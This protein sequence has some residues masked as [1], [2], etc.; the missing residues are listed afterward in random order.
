M[1]MA[2]ENGKMVLASSKMKRNHFTCPACN[3]TVFLRAGS[4]KIAHFAHAKDSDCVASEGETREHLLGKKQLFNW[5]KRHQYKPVYEVYLPEIKQRP[6]LLIKIG[7]QTVALEYQCSPISL[8]RL[9]ERN[10]GY[11]KMNIKVWWIL[12]SPYRHRRL[13]NVKVAQFTQFIFNRFDLLFWNTTEERF[14]YGQQYLKIDFYKKRYSKPWSKQVLMQQT[15][16]IN[17]QVMEGQPHLQEIVQQCYQAGHL[18]VGIPLVGHYLAEQWPSTCNGL[19][20]WQTQVLLESEKFQLGQQW[21]LTDWY[22]WLDQVGQR[23]WFLFPCLGSLNQIKKK[24]LQQFTLALQRYNV[25]A[26]DQ[27]VSYINLPQWFKDGT[28]KINYIRAL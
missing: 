6:D 25:I 27:D 2:V 24:Y 14:S 8:T 1:L 9:Q 28:A 21:S 19:T 18:F 5:A 26:I 7:R 11:R 16:S 3:Q 13:S 12:G 17:R 15:K 20:V 23:Q 10:A 22:D 4:V